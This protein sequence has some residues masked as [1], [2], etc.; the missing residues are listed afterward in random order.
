[1]F[2]Q[3]AQHTGLSPFPGPTVPFLEWKFQT[4]GEISS[5]PAIAHG[6][7][8]VGSSDG[9]LYA[10]N[11][12]GELLWKFQT[13]L[14]IRTSPAIGSDGTIYLGSFVRSASGRPE[15]ILYAINPG[16]KLNWN[17]TIVNSGE[18]I[19]SLSSPT[20]GPDG[21]IYVSDVGFRIV[22]VH[23]EGTIK[24]E[25]TTHG[26]VVD[27]PALAP[28]GT[29]YVGI[30]DP[31]PAGLCSQ[32]LVALNPDGTLKWGALPHRIGFSSPAVGSDGTIYLGGYAVN[33][34]GTVKW[35]HPGTFDSPSIGSDGTIYGEGNGGLNALTPDGTLQWQFSIEKSGG[36]CTLTGCSYVLVQQ[37]SVA[38]GSS[39]II[40]FGS[41]VTNLPNG[42][43]AFGAGT[44]YAV[45]P[46]GNLA[47]RFAT[48]SITGLCGP[49]FCEHIFS[50]SDPA[51]GSDGTIY[52]GTSDGNLYA[53][54]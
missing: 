39:G 14:P 42:G 20:I 2:H 1:M 4:G 29:V 17:L 3:N 37:S 44:L 24:W 40:Y 16:G 46:D 9:N 35:Q 7:I 11:R 54:H 13:S 12:Q 30:D 34:D 53:I 26:E 21:T 19:D 5:P 8:Y 41:G 43:S 25:L 28:D 49:G 27:S 38:I 36:S 10:L 48:G 23:P 50:V 6:R 15:G 51:I 18:G 33:P 52:V 22:A 32:C 31:G 47:W 45:N